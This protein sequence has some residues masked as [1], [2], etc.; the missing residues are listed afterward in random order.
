V[1]K[2]ATARRYAE[3]VFEIGV[4]QGTV[5]RWREDLST[6]AEYFGDHSLAFILGEPNIVFDRKELIVK[7]LLASK[8]QPDALGL[9]LLLV[10][11]GLVDL[12]KRI[13]TEYDQLYNDYH[14]QIV[15][16]V[17]TALPLE[18]ESREMVRR[19]LQEITG[20]KILLQERV[21]PSILGGAIARVGDTLIDGSVKRRL[22]L[23]RQQILRGGGGF[24][25]ANDG[26]DGATAGAAPDGA[27]AAS[28]ATATA[29]D[30]EGTRP[31][32]VAPHEEPDSANGDGDRP[33]KPGSDG[34]S[35]NEL[36]PRRGPSPR[37]GPPGNGN[38]GR[39]DRRDNRRNR[40][41]RR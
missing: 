40:G 2:G 35:S 24:G 14:N 10:E 9:A 19:D 38:P 34:S 33:E 26:R 8:L 25:G 12:A 15:A 5:D 16:E 6:I 20:K 22:T 23:L 37:M 32:V 36:G 31:F 41:R 17:T 39:G 30:V 7:D 21:D 29:A 3:A 11:R 4:E 28:T 1:L 13:F 27:T 18:A